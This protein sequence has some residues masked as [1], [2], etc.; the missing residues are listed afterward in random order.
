MVIALFSTR[1]RRHAATRAAT[2]RRGRALRKPIGRCT[3]CGVRFVAT[4]PRADDTR[5]VLSAH[6]A[7]CPGGDRRHETAEPFAGLD[8]T[9]GSA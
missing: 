7:A 5:V 9:R 1:L 8:P 6:Q 3:R 2:R 4:R